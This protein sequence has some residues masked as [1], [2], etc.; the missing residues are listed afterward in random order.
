[1]RGPSRWPELLSAAAPF[2]ALAFALLPL[3]LPF[4]GHDLAAHVVR[5]AQWHRGL[6][7]GVFYPLYLHDVF[8]G[9]GAPVMLF[10]PPLP[11]VV[12]EL[13]VLLGAGPVAALKLGLALGFVGGSAAVYFL[14]REALGRP[15]AGLA[16]AAYAI[17]PYR[18]LDGWVRA[19]YPELIATALLPLLL[20]A[21]RRMATAAGGRGWAAVAATLAM[22]LLTHAPTSLVGIGLATVYG[23]LWSPRGARGAVLLRLGLAVALGFGLSAFYLLPAAA[24]I[25]RT[26]LQENIG[27]GSYFFY[28]Y[29]FVEPRQLLDTGWG[30]GESVPGPADGMSFQMGRVHLAAAAAALLIAW[31]A[32]RAARRELLFWLVASALGVY[33]T[34][35]YSAWVWRAV[36]LLHP[37]QFPW[38]MLMVPAL[39]TSLLVGALVLPG[40]RWPVWARGTLVA[41][42]LA[43]LVISYAPFVVPLPPP[44]PMAPRLT[45]EAL[46]RWIGSNPVW[47]PRGVR[48]DGLP[49][50]RAV[51]VSGSG[52]LQIVRDATHVF[53]A[54]SRAA[55]PFTVRLR[56]FAFPG[57]QASL[58]GLVLPARVEAATGAILLDLPAGEHEVALRFGMTPIRRTATLVSLLTVALGGVAWIILGPPR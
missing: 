31:R 23:L 11:Y 42:V 13:F 58:D 18:L 46:Q 32:P 12:S 48:P 30:Y 33:L 29:H 39:G 54:R 10:N 5:I 55:A 51:I 1:M 26:Q 20:L 8:W 53:V 43:A 36:P 19:A 16:A 45:P 37:F 3:A 4:G 24:E 49:G 52:E 2:V 27:P 17:V 47:L 21:A 38:R 56:I 6:T 9:F 35:A 50:P 28:G 34:T 25:G 44:R 40:E 22:L 15:A 7:E 14:A 57:W 41:A